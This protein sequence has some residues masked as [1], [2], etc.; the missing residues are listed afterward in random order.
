VTNPSG[1]AEYIRTLG[2]EGLTLDVSVH[3]T[4][5]V[6]KDMVQIAGGTYPIGW[7]GGIIA[8]QLGEKGLANLTSRVPEDVKLEAFYID[9]Y[10]VSNGQYEAFLND[11]GRAM[12]LPP[13]VYWDHDRCPAEI[14]KKPVVAVKWEHALAYAE[15][16]GKRLP[17]EFEWEAAARGLERR[18]YPWGNDPNPTRVHSVFDP[19]KRPHTTDLTKFA[20]VD[21]MPEGATPTGLHHMLGNAVQWVWN[22]WDPRSS[23]PKNSWMR[24]EGRRTARGFDLDSNPANLAGNLTSR[25]ME[26]PNMPNFSVGFRCAKSVLR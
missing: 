17:T 25:K 20:D 5:E 2:E 10:C 23:A 13:P 6:V 3:P 7:N 26:S 15:W 22:P 24:E 18:L 11:R 21:S 1:S 19:V 16:A 12:G 8:Q 4:A 9:K 14:A